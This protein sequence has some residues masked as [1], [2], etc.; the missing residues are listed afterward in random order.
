MPSEIDQVQ[1]GR[2]VEKVEQLEKSVETLTESIN[3]LTEKLNQS[4]GA[5]WL[6]GRFGGAAAIIIVALSWL[7][8]HIPHK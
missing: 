5:L 8:D 2:F 1:F 6:L 4:K 3:S 7:W